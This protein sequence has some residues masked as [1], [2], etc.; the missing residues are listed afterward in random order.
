M[1]YALA[2]LMG[3][4]T[5]L[6]LSF[7][8]TPVTRWVASITGTVLSACAAI[9]LI[10]FFNGDATVSLLFAWSA[11]IVRVLADGWAVEGHPML[12]G[13]GYRSRVAAVF[14]HSPLLRRSY[15][16]W[17]REQQD[18]APMPPLDADRSE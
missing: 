13:Y 18:A 7:T 10:I 16:E 8:S 4:T 15:S 2:V 6:M 1:E 12:R 17:L 14:F 3:I 11:V 9:L 5:G